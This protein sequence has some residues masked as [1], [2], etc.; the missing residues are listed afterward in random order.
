MAIKLLFVFSS[1]ISLIIIVRMGI[2]EDYAGD[3]VMCECGTR[4]T[5]PKIVGTG[6]E[7]K[8]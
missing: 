8:E 7:G 2:S 1:N 4:V 3:R 6:G 5:D